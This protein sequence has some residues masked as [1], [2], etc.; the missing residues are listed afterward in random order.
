M[1]SFD[2]NT[3]FLNGIVIELNSRHLFKHAISLYTWMEKNTA[4]NHR[5]NTSTYNM[6]ILVYGSM[7]EYNK[8]WLVF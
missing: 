6:I 8:A 1:I 4:I 5:P 2:I 7:E 3:F